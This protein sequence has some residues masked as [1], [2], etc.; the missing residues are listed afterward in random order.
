[1]I[2]P[3]CKVPKT[4]AAEPSSAKWRCRIRASANRLATFRTARKS[5]RARAKGGTRSESAVEDVKGRSGKGHILKSKTEEL[6][7][8]VA[9][10]RIAFAVKLSN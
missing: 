1:M 4:E 6:R 5:P 8:V 10:V 9:F 7:R 3:R 2:K